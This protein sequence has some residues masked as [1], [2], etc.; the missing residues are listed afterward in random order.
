M[1]KI[2][3]QIFKM[4]FLYWFSKR[5]GIYIY[6]R[7]NQNKKSIEL[8]IWEYHKIKEL[9]GYE[10]DWFSSWCKNITI[11]RNFIKLK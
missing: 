7:Q 2:F 8:S 3:K 4:E 10:D 6:Y 1:K 9:E 5:L 11:W